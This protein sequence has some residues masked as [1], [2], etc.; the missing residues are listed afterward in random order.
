MTTTEHVEREALPLA[1]AAACLGITPDALR[2][3]IRRGRAEG[4][5]RG[6]RLFV[7]LPEIAIAP[8]ASE[9]GSN[10][11][12]DQGS[13]TASRRESIPVVVEFQKI[14]ITRLL[15]DNQRLNERLDQS[16][17]EARN[18]REMLQREQVLR[19]Q[20]QTIRQQMQRLL[21]HL[22]GLM[23]L[24]RPSS[25]VVDHANQSDPDPSGESEIEAADG[26]EAPEPPAADPGANPEAEADAP[27]AAA[28][29]AAEQ[30]VSREARP[31]AAELAEM[32]KEL[33]ESLR[34]VEAGLQDAPVPGNN[35]APMGDVPG[36]TFDA[37]AP[38]E[39]E[40]RNAARMMKKL[41]RNRAAPRER[42]P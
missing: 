24:P 9:H 30:P 13:P 3:R 21:D 5:K 42:E 22:T 19:Q 4:F 36:E 39:E 7:Y 16:L 12:G 35:G 8:G 15:R 28:D 27:E 6:G 20:D 2:M 38:S 26:T 10:A 18:L 34:E 37:S 1:E 31:E 25:E 29:P 41:F 40:R 17:D 11:S 33:G 23:A 32:L 14:E